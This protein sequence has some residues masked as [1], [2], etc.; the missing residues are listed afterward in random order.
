MSVPRHTA[1][2]GATFPSEPATVIV[3]MGG[4]AMGT[5]CAS[6]RA[7]ARA[8]QLLGVIVIVMGAASPRVARAASETVAAS[9]RVGTAQEAAQH[10]L[11]GGPCIALRVDRVTGGPADFGLGLGLARD[12]G[13]GTYSR[14]RVLVT[15][16]EAHARTAHRNR[17]HLELGLGHYW[18]D[19]EA[20]T[21][22]SVASSSKGAGGFIGAGYEFWR[23]SEL[24][25][26]ATLA[27][28]AIV[29]E[30]ALEGGNLGDYVEIAATLRWGGVT[31]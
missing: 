10:T 26:G 3:D 25:V 27:Y 7:V 2:S 18:I 17:A 31:R 13:G 20:T 1:A 22:S 19:R 8:R 30:F 28:H 15:S 14:D 12:P 23:N 21:S 9:L 16:I 29:Q 6:R 11:K 4:T 5:R 24:G